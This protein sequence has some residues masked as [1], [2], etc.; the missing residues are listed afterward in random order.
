MATSTIFWVREIFIGPVSCRSFHLQTSTYGL[1]PYA[2]HN[3]LGK[4]LLALFHAG[5]SDNPYACHSISKAKAVLRTQDLNLDEIMGLL[6]VG[7]YQDMKTD[8]GENIISS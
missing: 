6:S 5:T 4:F 2:H 8:E 3:I 7:S 1:N